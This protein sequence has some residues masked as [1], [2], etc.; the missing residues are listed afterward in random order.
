MSALDPMAVRWRKSSRSTDTGSNCVEVAQWRKSSRSDDTD[1]ACVEVAST[2]PAVAV[3]DS[4]NP[5]GPKLVFAAEAGERS[6]ATS[7]R[8]ATT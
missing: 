8:A 5:D 3:R 4:K 6:P 1:G 2:N 7:K